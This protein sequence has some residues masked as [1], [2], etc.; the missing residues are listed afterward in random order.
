MSQL[1]RIL[2]V[3]DYPLDRELVRDALEREHSGFELVEAA[4]RADFEIALAQGGFDLVLSDFNILGFEGLQVLETVHAQDANLPVIIVTGTG[5]EEV[6]AEAIKRGAADYVIKTPQHIQHLPHTIHT[7]LEKKRLE[8]ERKQTEEI[9]KE[10]ELKYRTIIERFAEGLALVDEQGYIVEWN[11]AMEQIFGVGRSEALGQLFWDLQYSLL[12]PERQAAQ[13]YVSLKAT[14]SAL[15]TGISSVFDKPTEAA[16]QTPHGE[17]KIIQQRAFFIELKKRRYIASVVQDITNRKRA[18]QEQERL[19][20]QM[21]EQA[22]QMEQILGTV[23]TGVL[24]LDAGWRVIQANP[25]AEKHLAILAGAEVGDSLSRLG[26]RPLAELLT[27]PPTRGLWHEVKATGQTFEVIARPVETGPEPEHWVL[28]INDVTREREVQIQLQRQERLAAV[29]QLAAGIAH[30]F[31]NIMAVM[32]LYTQMLLKMPGL[33]SEGRERLEIV[34]GQAMRAAAL[35]Q[36]ILDFSRHAVLERRP[37]DLAPF[38]KEVIKLLERIVPESIK[39]MLT[40]GIGTYI[41]NADPTRLQQAVMNLVINARDAMPNG[42]EL[43]ITLSRGVVTDKIRCVICGQFIE[44]EWVCIRMTDTG[45]GISSDVLPY[46]FDPFFTT[47]EVGKGTGLGLAQVYGIVAQH[48]G[49]IEV[50]TQVG[51]G[52]TF[53]IYLPALLEQPPE[54]PILEAQAYVYG[55][56]ETI[57]VVED[58]ESLRSALV[59]SLELLNYRGLQAANGREALE[60]LEQHAGEIALVLSDMV[61]PEMGGQA[62]FYALR[63]RGLTLPVVMLSGHPMENELE[64]LKTQGLAGWM[65]KPADIGQLSHLVGQALQEASERNLVE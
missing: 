18:E 43:S 35:T 32:M 51:K 10:S 38:L 1:V 7:V 41:V 39:I 45:I 59:D 58:D 54:A 46:I 17:F 16:I 52:T 49:H 55:H 8:A 12:C 27:S 44:G 3:D 33:T 36:Q 13:V 31:N 20:A 25:V 34:S 14:L 11:Q 62:L 6:A 9:L 2:Y 42:G 5:S 26:D 19:T 60:T 56:G 50:A 65:P 47:K 4:S 15:L 63:Q 29:G 57:L 22:Q 37:M 23:P 53:A 64:S 40:C 61:M 28:V 48:E 24:L 21:R 30:D